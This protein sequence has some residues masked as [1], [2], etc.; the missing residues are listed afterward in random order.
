MKRPRTVPYLRWAAALVLAALTACS[1][2]AGP[3]DEPITELPRE[4]SVAERSVIAASNRFGMELVRRVAVSDERANVVLSPLSAS[5]ALGMTLNGADSTTFDAMRSTLGFDSLSQEQINASYRDLI[6]LLT[7]LDPRVRFDIANAIWANE[8]VPFHDAFFE[9]VAASFDA[10]AESH[11]FAD[12]ATV[13]RINDWVSEHTGGLIDTLVEQLDP[14]LVMLLVNAIYLDA[15]W[16]LQ[17]DPDDTR[18]A[19]F[20]REDASAVTIE[21]MSLDYPT[22][23][24]TATEEYSAVELPYG[25]EAFSMVVMLP[26]QGTTVRDLLDGLDA[27]AWAELT[28]SLGEVEL[29]RVALPK[30][31]LTY[32]TWLNDAL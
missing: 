31:T 1:E 30:F 16:T 6:D 15:E 18:P 12:P 9:A 26:S 3:S 14:A 10:A 7:G 19:D 21:L 20:T 23:G 11:D 22:V 27:E 8:D 5:M 2:A 24:F 28:A 25:G 13:Q 17:F 32:D 4:L 29:G